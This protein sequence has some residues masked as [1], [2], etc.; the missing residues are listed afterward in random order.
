[1]T[2]GLYDPE[3]PFLAELES[4]VTAR[5][6]RAE[7]ERSRAAIH[8]AGPARPRPVAPL[9]ARMT[10]RTA[11]LAV[12]LCVAGATAFGAGSGL[13]S[14]APRQAQPRSTPVLNAHGA[15]DGEAWTLSLYAREGR[16]CRALVV[17]AQEAAS[18]CE[19]A[20]KSAGLDA[21]SLASARRRYVFGVTG[22]QVRAV[23]VRLGAERRIVPTLGVRSHGHSAATRYFIVIF[24]RPLGR[25]DPPALVTAVDAARDPVGSTRAICAGDSGSPPCRS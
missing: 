2:D 15:Q 25:P 22:T 6:Q 14:S 23:D 9:L 12:L 18:R 10:R 19:P 17:L 1:V 16:L 7:A 20:P 8:R 11:I 4:R 5:A 13:F 24:G 21:T 3:L